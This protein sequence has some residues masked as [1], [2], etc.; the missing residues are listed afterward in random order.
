M[1]TVRSDSADADHGRVGSWGLAVGNVLGALGLLIVL[2]L[3]LWVLPHVAE[4]L[5]VGVLRAELEMAQCQSS[6]NVDYDVV[7]RRADWEAAPG[8]LKLLQWSLPIARKRHCFY[9][10]VASR[11]DAGGDVAALTVDLY[12]QDG[13]DSKLQEH[14][15]ELGQGESRRLRGR[16]FSGS[17]AVPE[18]DVWFRIFGHDDFGRMVLTDLSVSRENWLY[19]TVLSLLRL[20]M[21]GVFG[22]FLWRLSKRS[23]VAAWCVAICAASIAMA[24]HLPSH[25]LLQKEYMYDNSM[26]GVWGDSSWFVPTTLSLLGEGNADLDEFEETVRKAQG[27]FSLIEVDGR[28]YN[29]FPIGTS[30]LTLP[31]LGVVNFFTGNQWW[32]TELVCSRI[33]FGLVNAAFFLLLYM[34]LGFKSLGRC[35]MWTILFACATSNLSTITTT[36]LSHGG[37]ELCL[38]TGMIGLAWAEYRGRSLGLALAAAAFAMAYMTRPTASPFIALFSVW[39]ALKH[40]RHL[41]VYIGTA[42]LVMLPFFLWSYLS[43]GHILPPYYRASRLNFDTYFQAG[44]GQMFSPNRGLFI[45]IPFY[46]FYFPSLWILFRR[47]PFDSLQLCLAL[48]PIPFV[49]AL[50]AFPHWWGGAGYGPRLFT[51]IAPMM[52]LAIACGCSLPRGAVQKRWSKYLLA[53]LILLSL[54]IQ[55]KGAYSHQ[56]FLWSSTPGM[57]NDV[58]VYPARIWEWSDMQIFR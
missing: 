17:R 16:I 1:Q 25:P 15:I 35:L 56:A 39:V 48:T 31:Y 6:E 26:Y 21:I 2:G 53:A 38:L 18:E 9:E 40:Y 32:L 12:S 4:R 45:F 7:S 50:A 51:D 10:F 46:L 44:L 11:S 58:D 43:F 23:P 41:H 22:V 36:L 30:L 14:A 3:L 33:M 49:L 5:P 20:I 37:L 42:L 55:F 57:D 29:Y 27:V 8:A 52:T 54:A 34:L 13:Y 24:A 28:H 47:R 19:R